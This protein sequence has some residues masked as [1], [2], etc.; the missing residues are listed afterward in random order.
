MDS[1]HP[2]EHD[3][4]DLNDEPEFASENQ[5][6][7]GDSVMGMIAGVEERISQL[8]R[9][10]DEHRKASEALD[11]SRVEFEA[12]R[13]R[14]AADRE[15]LE[16]LASEL[17]DRE[18]AAAG[19][20]QEHQAKIEEIEAK[21]RELSDRES[22][23]AAHEDESRQLADRLERDRQDLQDRM[24]RVQS[25]VD[26]R[27][28]RIDERQS[29]LEDLQGTIDER[30]EEAQRRDAELIEREA[31]LRELNVSSGRVEEL[32]ARLGQREKII[33]E[34]RDQAERADEEL[35]SARDAMLRAGGA[36]EQLG[37]ARRECA[38]LRSQVAD[39][40]KQLERT[41]GGTEE[42]DEA[43]NRIDHLEA[44]L[45]VAQSKVEQTASSAAEKVAT[46]R[47]N[48]ERLRAELIELAGSRDDALGT[49]SAARERLEHLEQ[50]LTEARAELAEAQSARGEDS[51]TTQVLTT[52]LEAACKRA[53][54]AEA[55]VAR[56]REA[57]ERE[58]SQQSVRIEALE[59]DLEAAREQIEAASQGGAEALVAERER[60]DALQVRVTELESDEQATE[61][62][63]RIEALE[64][65]LDQTRL[66]LDRAE[67]N[68][69]ERADEDTAAIKR[70]GA[71]VEELEAQREQ[72]QHQLA[73][74]ELRPRDDREVGQRRDRLRRQRDLLRNQSRKLNSATKALRDRFD[75][76]EQIL[77]RRAELSEAYQAVADSE[78]KLSNRESR[79]SAVLLLCAIVTIMGVVGAM[80]WFVSGVTMPGAHAATA[81]VRADAGSRDLTE[82]DVEGWTAYVNGLLEDPAFLEMVSDRMKRRGIASLA[83]PG[84]LRT[85][86]ASS[87]DAQTPEPGKVVFEL[88]GDGRSKTERV[89]DTFV[90]AMAS[91]ANHAR[92]RRSDGATTVVEQASRV[93]TDPLDQTRVYAAGGMFSGGML[94]AM[95][96]G[97]VLWRRMRDSKAKFERDA[98]VDM[99]L[100]ESR[101]GDPRGDA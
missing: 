86:V 40:H 101:W 36:A 14:V 73:E 32:E 43:Q 78:A 81:I 33:A 9:L 28:K 11:Q 34:M 56:L 48:T 24:T 88:R 93:R 39:L 10:H 29:R 94:L 50:Q 84:A 79:H 13:D 77:S 57:G 89:L 20:E 1:Q 53:E 82:A 95:I 5:P 18:Q 83:T 17:A 27:W 99:I 96:G 71:R 67:R 16:Q 31:Q 100:D 15:H 91:H 63:L 64:G 87:L 51:E 72:M 85:T 2:E 90:V 19:R 47:E 92:S 23:F 22:R 25:E 12:D 30:L 45:E 26:A 58:D 8:K 3:L 54:Q 75:Q 7:P 59:A 80:S 60:A 97:N 74:A 46:E 68:N 44:E 41:Q 37:E 66:A 49:A 62:Q 70:L 69:E 38:D 76:V 42:L 52:E 35:V 98:R 6:G 21:L 61:Y 65:D 55:M 4:V